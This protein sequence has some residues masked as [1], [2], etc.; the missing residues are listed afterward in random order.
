MEPYINIA[1]QAARK[2]GNYI[3]RYLDRIDT[4]NI[5]AKDKND[6]VSDVDI[7]AENIIIEMIT[8]NYPDHGILA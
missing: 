8:K 2:A 5:Q 4:L 6:Y 3:V 7:G 1:I